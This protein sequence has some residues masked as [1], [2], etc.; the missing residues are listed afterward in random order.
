MIPGALRVALGAVRR[1]AVLGGF[2]ATAW[3]AAAPGVARAAELVMFESP[4]CEWCA[5]WEREVGVV[6]HK[7]EEGR[8]APLRRVSLAGRR[9]SD[10]TDLA[11]IVYTPTFVLIE[12]GRE[13]GRILGYPGE[14]HFWGLLGE[15]IRRL[16]GAPAEG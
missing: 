9:P 2:A 16:D 4:V 8:R 13:R 3:L 14:A 6:Y 15:L 12:H 10:L 5:V 1:I 7:T 11:G